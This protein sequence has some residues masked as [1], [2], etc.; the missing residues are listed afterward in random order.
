MNPITRRYQ[1]CGLPATLP[2]ERRE[3]WR[4]YQDGGAVPIHLLPTNGDT[5]DAATRGGVQC[6]WP[7][8]IDGSCPNRAEH[9]QPVNPYA[10]LLKE[11]A[12]ERFGID[13]AEIARVDLSATGRHDGAGVYVDLY[14]VLRDDSFVPLEND[15]AELGSIGELLTSLLRVDESS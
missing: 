7:L 6:E 14:V 8:L 3:A 12:A 11:W 1:E 10:T 2:A 15:S 13:V 5:C 9:G 4:I